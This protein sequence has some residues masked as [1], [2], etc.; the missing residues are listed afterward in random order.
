MRLEVDN[1]TFDVEMVFNDISIGRATS[2]KYYYLPATR[3]LFI[4]VMP[5]ST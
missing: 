5:C 3:I 1:I 4:R 2:F